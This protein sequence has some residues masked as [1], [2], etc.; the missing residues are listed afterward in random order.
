MLAGKNRGVFVEM[1]R[2][3]L[4]IAVTAPG[5][6]GRVVEKIADVA[7]ES[8]REKL[9]EFV[10]SN[11]APA[12]AR[13]ATGRASV[14]PQARFFHRHSADAPVKLREA[15]YFEEVLS[16]QLGVDFAANAVSVISAVDGMAFDPARSL[17]AQR[18]LL[19]C[20][21]PLAELKAL[22]EELVQCGLVPESMEIGSLSMLGAMVSI[23]RQSGRK[24]PA[25]LLETATASTGLYIVSP[26][27]V[28]LCRTIPIG[29]DSML[30]AL[31]G[32]LGMK[33]EKSARGIL[34]SNTFDFT[35]M[36]QTLLARLIKEIKASTGFYEVQTGQT[37]GKVFLHLLP[38]GLEWV[39]QCL[40][41]ALGMENLR[42]DLATWLG[43]SGVKIA[44]GVEA[45]AEKHLG[46]LSLMVDHEG[47]TES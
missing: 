23:L 24:G 17:A 25:L 28:D 40:P 37:I 7:L 31:A 4:T 43:A 36:G 10:L 5:S 42:I 26:D 45:V 38:T 3:R 22:Q 19:F 13:F 30:P 20:G 46:V 8:G 41:R 32:E 14:Y 34:Y 16:G 12:K 27:K 44:P 15:G 18:E 11:C 33:D 47:R 39:R 29:L 1:G 9:R 35:E 6:P 2:T 21:A